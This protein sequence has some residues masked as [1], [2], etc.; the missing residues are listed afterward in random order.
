MVDK[1]ERWKF[2][3]LIVMI[4]LSLLTFIKQFKQILFS[5]I[6]CPNL[7]IL[8]FRSVPA[9]RLQI[10]N[11]FLNNSMLSIQSIMLISFLD[12]SFPLSFEILLSNSRSFDLWSFYPS[13]M[14]FWN[15]TI[16]FKVLFILVMSLWDLG[17]HEISSALAQ[18]LKL[19]L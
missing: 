17:F 5:S 6:K 14:F 15:I 3:R 4:Q 2:F 13:E 11:S 19:F 16:L 8:I 18:M 12:Q 10:K 9:L 7:S 1:S